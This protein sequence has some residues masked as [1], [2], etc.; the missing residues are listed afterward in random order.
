M[1]SETKKRQIII[2]TFMSVLALAL[3]VAVYSMVVTLNHSREDRDLQ[4]LLT[5]I[6]SEIYDL[7]VVSQDAAVGDME[8][9]AGLPAIE[10]SIFEKQQSFA[11]LSEH[12]DPTNVR[13]L[14]EQ[15]NNVIFNLRNVE[16]QSGNIEFLREQLFNLEASIPGIQQRYT[17][18]VDTMLENDSP[19]DQIAEAQAQIWRLERAL[20][21]LNRI[22]GG[23]DMRGSYDPLAAAG[24]FRSDVLVFVEVFIGMRDGNRVLGI[25]QVEDSSVRL[26]LDQIEIQFQGINES[27]EALVGAAPALS[28]TSESADAILRTGAELLTNT[29]GLSTEIA[30]LPERF[31]I[32]P[33]SSLTMTA[34]MS[35]AAVMAILIGL[36]IIRGTR[37]NLLT[38]KLTNETNEEAI[39]RLLDEIGDLGEGDLTVSATV[40][41]D[42]TGAIADSI[43]YAIEELRKLVA[44]VVV[45]AESVAGASNETRAIAL[46]LNEASEHQS[47]QISDT[48]KSIASVADN[49]TS[50]SADAEELASVAQSSVA[51]AS[52]GNQ[53]VQNS[54][55][56]MNNIRE[57]IQDTA[58][59][60]KRL[61]ESS[62]EIG[63]I[64]SLINDIADQ[65]NILALNASIQA[66]MAGEAGRGFAV[67]ADEVQSLAERAATSTKQIESLVR[68]IQTDTNETVE[69]MEQTTAEVVR[70]AEL[71]NSAGASLTEIQS[72]S[73]NLAKLILAISGAAKE[74][75]ENANR[76]SRSMRVISDITEQT[77]AGS[78]ESG[79][80]IG[81]LAEQAVRLRSSV[82]DF[83]LP[84]DASSNLDNGDLNVSNEDSQIPDLTDLIIEDDSTDSLTEFEP[85]IEEETFE[86]ESE[87]ESEAS[88]QAQTVPD[89]LFE[90]E[91]L[92]E[93]DWDIGVDI[94]DEAETQSDSSNTEQNLDKTVAEN[95]ELS[96]ED[97]D[98]D[99][100]FLSFDIDLDEEEDEEESQP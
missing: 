42:F 67:V 54:I 56:G 14:N 40:S 97:I 7:M 64:V 85:E 84:E 26:L 21:S 72:T 82:D 76:A 19:A 41:E 2:F 45:T 93:L 73:E 13:R 70:G 3:A 28:I 65:T 47:S 79:K 44:N 98:L 89:E 59:R 30:G 62:Q 77:L 58:K 86:L 27:I 10:Q 87:S 35:I 92:D 80:A 43:N 99:E 23:D 46:R 8:S 63:D 71:A 68:A 81:E 15:L 75:S 95:D 29:Q 96:I 24:Q 74:Q 60:I 17:Q 49:L 9:I 88:L 94:I 20:A 16:D 53:V 83:K 12:L 61:G 38:Q 31:N 34:A 48:T 6:Q 33:F 69:S 51:V 39:L 18:V 57:Q 55:T 36:L 52:K 78:A 5:S 91:E 25:S 1:A 100:D 37:E 50:V 11:S 90:I 32:R 4:T 66:A 22:L